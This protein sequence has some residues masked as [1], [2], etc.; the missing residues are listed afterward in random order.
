[1]TNAK[2]FFCYWVIFYFWLDAR[3][4]VLAVGNLFFIPSITY[5]PLILEFIDIDAS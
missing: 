4:V 1:M 2:G 3:G 5:S